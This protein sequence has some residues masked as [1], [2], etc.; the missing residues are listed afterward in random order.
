MR[1]IRH[2]SLILALVLAAVS[3]FSGAT[4]VAEQA[5]AAHTHI[6]T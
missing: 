2:L 6:G 4:A 1:Q 3:L 5:S